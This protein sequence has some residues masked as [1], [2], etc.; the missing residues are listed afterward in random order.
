MH[1]MAAR[2]T[3]IRIFLTDGSPEGIRVI[4]KS[5]WT[6]RAVMA[7]RTQI[8]DALQRKEL[9]RPGVYVL[10][11]TDANGAQIIYIGEADLLRYRLKQHVGTKEFWEHF[12]AFSCTDGTLNKAHVRYLEYRLITLAKKANQWAVENTVIPAEPPLSEADRAD[13]EWFLSEMLIIFPILGIDAFEQA[14][15]TIKTASSDL[16]L[17]ERSAEARGQEAK[18]GFVVRKGSR[19]RLDETASIH[20]YIHELRRQLIERNVLI[21]EDN[22][23]VFSQDYRFTS[24]STAAGVLVGGTSNGRKAWK[25]TTGKM[26]RELQEERLHNKHE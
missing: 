17:S 25:T 14:S 9:A 22:A 7:S 5:N 1:T 6:G 12:V 10:S 20:K 19:A 24:P 3:S 4:S 15:A 21:E 13:A 11:G 18:D 16:V 26:L 2:P 8:E 23:L